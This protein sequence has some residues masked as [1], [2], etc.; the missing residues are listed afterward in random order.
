MD[1]CRTA[2]LSEMSKNMNPKSA[3]ALVWASVFVTFLGLS[4]TSPGAQF[5]SCIVAAALAV[6]PA[7]FSSK[8]TRVAGGVMLAI[9]LAFAYHGYPAFKKEG[10]DYRKRVEVVSAQPHAQQ[11]KK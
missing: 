11:E 3:S 9:S 10:E 7:F 5:L 4:V 6:T 2:A 8:K 1:I